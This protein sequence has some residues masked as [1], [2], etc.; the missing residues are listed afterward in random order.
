MEIIMDQQNELKAYLEREIELVDLIETEKWTFDTY[1][2]PI[3]I[4]PIIQVKFINIA[5]IKFVTLYF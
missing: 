1:T 5:F 4:L 3:K 2:T